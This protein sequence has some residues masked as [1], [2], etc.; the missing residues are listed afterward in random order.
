MRII[1]WDFNPSLWPTLAT[2]LILPMFLSLGFWQLDRAELKRVLHKDFEGR[3]S[4]PV[5]DLNEEI[6]VKNGLEELL[7]HKVTIKGEFSRDANILLD[8]QVINGKAGYFVYTPFKFKN[9]GFWILVNRGWLPAGA[10]RDDPPGLIAEEGVL[11]IVGSIKLPPS[12][13]MLLAENLAE[14]L[15]D[16]TI[17]VQKL[18]FVAIE[19]ALKIELLPNVVR[20]EPESAGGFTRHWKAPGS[21]EEK[22]LGYAFQWFAMA[23]AIFIIYLILNFKRTK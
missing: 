23:G 7:W 4:A 3:Q 19:K 21:G 14:Q 17:R 22:H 1:F 16:G 8:N 12:T 13:G 10:S 9:E 20:L 11:K 2:L 5:L 15:G 6:N 18:E